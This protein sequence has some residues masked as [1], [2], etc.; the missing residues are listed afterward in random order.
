MCNGWGA[1][2]GAVINPATPVE[3]LHEILQFVDYVLIMS[4]N[5]GFGGQKF[6]PT[7]LDKV[8]R[9][10][11]I[12]DQRGLPVRIEIDGGI[13]LGNIQQVLEAGAEIIVAGSAIFGAEDPEAAVRELREATIQWV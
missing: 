5:P 1:Q 8:R 11:R 6:I 2:A 4:V 12:I 3:S 10:R 13:D 9:V 7:A